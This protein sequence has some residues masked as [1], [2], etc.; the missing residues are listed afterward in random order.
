MIWLILK[1]VQ[2][3]KYRL[4]KEDVLLHVLILNISNVRMFLYKYIIQSI[5]GWERMGNGLVLLS[6]VKR[7]LNHILIH[8]ILGLQKANVKKMP[9]LLIC[10]S[11]IH[12]LH[13]NLINNALNIKSILK[14]EVVSVI[15][16]ILNTNNVQMLL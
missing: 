9:N 7:V 10:K 12:K 13:L 4:N 15:A 2:N 14:N 11:I 8:R 3:I 16:R 5:V 6:I 1:T